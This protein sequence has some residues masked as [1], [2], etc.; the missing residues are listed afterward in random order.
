[1]LE[2]L[3]KYIILTYVYFHTMKVRTI[4]KRLYNLLISYESTIIGSFNIAR[5]LC[6]QKCTPLLQSKLNEQ[7]E[8]I[9]YRFRKKVSKLNLAKKKTLK[10]A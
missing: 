2:V 8:V 5:Y 1:M 10:L 3:R 7:S 9:S 6:Y 4:N